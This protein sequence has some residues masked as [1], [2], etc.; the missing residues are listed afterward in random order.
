MVKGSFLKIIHDSMYDVGT[1]GCVS[2]K[3]II[4][5]ECENHFLLVS[6]YKHY[7]LY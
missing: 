2:E 4:E 5:L 7:S 3:Y 1:M 6:W